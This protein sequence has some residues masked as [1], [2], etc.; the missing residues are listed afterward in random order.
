M[1]IE[2]EIRQ[3]KFRNPYHKVAINVLFTAGWIEGHNKEYFKPFGVTPQQFNILRILR[4]Q[5][6]NKIS[7]TEIKSRML[8]RNSDVSRLVTRLI[9]KGL[10]EKSQCPKDK[11]ASDVLITADGLDLLKRIDQRV[12]KIDLE[13]FRLTAAEADHLNDLLDKCRG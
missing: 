12:D 1:K 7:V 2:D 3:S 8:D 4:G 6:P 5:F 9:S 11:R 13:L 10:I